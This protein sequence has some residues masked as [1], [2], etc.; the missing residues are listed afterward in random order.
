M[1]HNKETAH[2]QTQPAQAAADAKEP[3]AGPGLEAFDAEAPSEAGA[4]MPT[5]LPAAALC[6][7]ALVTFCVTTNAKVSDAAKI[8][9]G[10]SLL[11]ALW[12]FFGA[13]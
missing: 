3:A 7:A 10:V 8:V 4:L 13:R 9:F 2:G 6:A 1:A 5:Y 11:V 12:L